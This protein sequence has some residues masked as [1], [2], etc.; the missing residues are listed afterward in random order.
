MLKLGPRIGIAKLCAVFMNP[1]DALSKRIKDL[2]IDG[3]EVWPG[4]DQLPNFLRRC[5]GSLRHFYCF[6]SYRADG[7]P[8]Q[9]LDSLSQCNSLRSLKLHV[10]FAQESAPHTQSSSHSSDV[11]GQ[12]ESLGEC[13]VFHTPGSL[14][15]TPP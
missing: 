1:A 3:L 12:A 11:P 5:D 2:S 14:H 6:S 13:I 15:W 7:F 4:T 8:K 9:F 10:R